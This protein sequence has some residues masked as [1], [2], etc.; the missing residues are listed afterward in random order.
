MSSCK[1]NKEENSRGIPPPQMLCIF[2]ICVPEL[3][4]RRYL[5]VFLSEY[6]SVET[7]N[8]LRPDLVHFNTS[9]REVY[10]FWGRD[11]NVFDLLCNV[12]VGMSFGAL[13]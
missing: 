7:V 3:H 9:K 2:I 6:E 1:G 12:S 8:R 4:N 10:Y 5:S 11:F 13:L